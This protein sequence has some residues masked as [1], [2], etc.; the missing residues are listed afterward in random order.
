MEIGGRRKSCGVG[1]L[2]EIHISRK[3]FLAFADSY[4]IDEVPKRRSRGVAEK[5]A[6]IAFIEAQKRGAG[7]QRDLLGKMLVDILKKRNELLQ[8]TKVE[9]G[10]LVCQKAAA[11]SAS[12]V[13]LRAFI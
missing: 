8:L 11:A 2:G 4:E 6:E 9:G 13:F 3:H 12:A 10:A 1:D 7:I 5:A